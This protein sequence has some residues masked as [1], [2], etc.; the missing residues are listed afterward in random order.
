[1]LL[2]R[3]FLSFAGCAS[4]SE[5]CPSEERNTSSDIG[6]L[7]HHELSHSTAE[8]LLRI[9]DIVTCSSLKT[10]APIG[11]FSC[12][13]NDSSGTVCALWPRSQKT[14]ES[15]IRKA[16]PSIQSP[17]VRDSTTLL[18]LAE[19]HSR[20]RPGELDCFQHSQSRLRIRMLIL[21]ATN[22]TRL[23]RTPT[24]FTV[25]ILSPLQPHKVV[26]QHQH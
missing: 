15:L 2:Y 21:L 13:T 17:T 1:V 8:A 14:P 23:P 12:S 6:T 9:D 16:E 24:F 5:T 20:C 19:S 26:Q 10:S 11:E 4:F 3:S 22:Q 18:F 7:N 25:A